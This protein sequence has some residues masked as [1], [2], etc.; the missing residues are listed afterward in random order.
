[1]RRSSKAKFPVIAAVA[2]L[3][4]SSVAGALLVLGDDDT[5]STPPEKSEQKHSKLGSRLNQ[6]ISQVDSGETTA[7]EAAMLS[8]ISLDDSVAVAIH[9]TGRV[10]EVASFLRSNGGDPR[11]IGEGYIEAY[12]PLSLLGKTAEQPGVARLREIIPPLAAH[13]EATSQG[14]VEHGSEPWNEVGFRGQGIKIGI[15]D[16]GFKGFGGLMGTELPSEVRARCYRTVALYSSALADC[17]TTLLGIREVFL[18]RG[19]H[20]TIVAEAVIDV[21]PEAYLYIANPYTPED[22]RRTVEWMIAEG[23]SVINHSRGW[24]FGGPGDGTSPHF[25]DPLLTV[26]RAV[27]A[28]M[29]WVNSAGNEA[30]RTWFGAYSDVDQDGY[31]NIGGGFNPEDNGVELR[32]GKPIVV[33]LRWDDD[34][35][36]AESDLDLLL[37]SQESS[38]SD[39]QKIFGFE[40]PQRL[41]DLATTFSPRVP[42]IVGS[43]DTQSGRPGDVPL[44]WLIVIPKSDGRYNL[45]VV[46]RSGSDPDWIQLMV[47]PDTVQQIDHYTSAN[48]IISPAESSNPGMLA[49]GAAPWYNTSL[50]ESYSS[51]GP[52]PD[53]R[54]KPDIVGATC[55]ESV[56]EPLRNGRRGFCGTSQ[57]APHVAGMA[58]LVRQ[59]FPEYGPKEVVNYLRSHAEQKGVEHPNNSWG[60]GFA[61]LPKLGSVCVR[62]LAQEGPNYGGWAEGCH[63]RVPGRG[64]AQFFNLVVLSP[65][66]VSLTLKSDN[67]DPYLYLREGYAVE[68]PALHANNDVGAGN[69]NSQIRAHLE[70]G[71]YSVETTTYS[72]GETGSFTLTV[73]FEV[74]TRSPPE[75]EAVSEV[76]PVDDCAAV[77]AQG[78][79][80]GQLDTLGSS[81]CVAN[82]VPDHEGIGVDRAALIALYEAT[83][84]PNWQNSENWLTDKPLHRWHRVYTD[85]S[86]RVIQVHLSQNALKGEIPADISK[87]DR[88]EGLDLSEN[89]LTGEIPPALGTL[90]NLQYL[91]LKEN[92]LSGEI[93]RAIGDLPSLER[94][95]LGDNQFRGE[96]PVELA[97]L[98]TLEWLS[99]RY[100]DLTGEIP[101][102]LGK[103]ANL[104][105]LWLGGNQLEGQ[106]PRELAD[107]SKLESLGLSGNGLTGKIPPELGSMGK[108][109]QLMLIQNQLS[110]EIPAELGGLNNLRTLFLDHNQLSGEIPEQLGKLNNLDFLQLGSNPLTGCIPGGLR[111]VNK[112]DDVS[113]LGLPFCDAAN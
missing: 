90:E 34:W 68:G 43:E 61:K 25:F 72:P 85:P 8:P 57:S 86:G 49:V 37:L 67:A 3:A 26:D 111:Y 44:E 109:E 22:H 71:T 50:I 113:L 16:A 101:A 59:R 91:D 6:I 39:G 7:R 9:V 19:D 4:I 73:E 81:H 97:Q 95:E 92:Q 112:N 69:A 11:N 46:H 29:V 20:G 88:L 28:G 42:L 110:G 12:V 108:L 93:P 21:A 47:S 96:I 40:I 23:V 31:L 51:R 18:G 75:D 74:S 35:G 52:T 87:M 13:G 62:Q 14:V 84:G 56:L 45:R 94:L 89:Q 24:F 17:E 106:I 79:T 58:A 36:R 100:N 41:S 99:L 107:L 76:D 104:K 54:V 10:D 102:E 83:D 53:G 63:S 30:R 15:I 78:Q 82:F 2:A 38:R 98:T 60:Y 66:E 48:S 77:G 32:M 5:L 33:Q 27:D 80:A 1:M 105:I 55:A 65:A 70:G 103:L 64:Y